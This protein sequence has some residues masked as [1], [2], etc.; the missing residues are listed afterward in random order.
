MPSEDN[1]N[2][3]LAVLMTCHNRVADTRSCLEA[4]RRQE[5]FEGSIELVLTDDGSTDGTDQ[6]AL[7]IFPD[8]TVI[9]GDGNLYWCGGMRAAF[10]RAM[11]DN[12]DFYLWLNDDTRMDN[13]AIAR[14]YQT[15]REASTTLGELLIVV[16]STQDQDSNDMSYGGWRLSRGRLGAISWDK[17]R[18][19]QKDWTYCDAMNG[20]FVLI[21]RAVVERNGN[22]DE[23]FTHG[24][25]DLD[26]GLR[27]KSAGCSIV[28]APGYYGVCS[29]NDGAGLWTDQRLPVMERWKKMLGPKG[30]P[31]REW[32]VFTR[33]HG[34]S[35]WPLLW[36]GP[37]VKFWINALL[38]GVS[39][40]K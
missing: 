36:L 6:A 40:G 5:S 27:A 29:A 3:R 10:A 25:G 11:Q 14:I 18:P 1:N 38:N 8:A 23:A 39:N 4:V 12:Y 26:Y 2:L 24:M 30:L 32:R 16:G 17:V 22:L 20:N 33:R 13:D 34:G 28:I 15:Y 21:P 35:Y 7:D 37:Y 19:D 9:K 31:V